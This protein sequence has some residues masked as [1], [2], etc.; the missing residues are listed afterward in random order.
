MKIRRRRPCL[1]GQRWE[2]R[3]W[4]NSGSRYLTNKI[5][6]YNFVKPPK[7]I[8]E[9]CDTVVPE[10]APRYK[11]LLPGFIQMFSTPPRIAAANFDRNGR[12][13]F[14]NVCKSINVE[15]TIYKKLLKKKS[16][17][18]GFQALYSFLTPFS[19]LSILFS[20]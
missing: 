3:F 8:S 10:A 11:T 2:E 5:A 15:M 20:P 14:V 12:E 7:P 17:S 4:K 13:E 1:R 19:S 18:N 16:P 6:Q 9:T